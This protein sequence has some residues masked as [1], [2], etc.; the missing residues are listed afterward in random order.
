MSKTV[1]NQQVLNLQLVCTSN[2]TEAHK[3]KKSATDLRK[4]KLQSNGEENRTEASD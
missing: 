3:R 1:E 2:P 4:K